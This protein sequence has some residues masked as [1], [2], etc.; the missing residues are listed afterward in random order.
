MKSYLA[1]LNFRRQSEKVHD[2]CNLLQQMLTPYISLAPAS[3]IC[4][5]ARTGHSVIQYPEPV[6]PVAQKTGLGLA[7]NF[8]RF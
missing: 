8:V 2:I 7:V 6:L 4:A 5:I 3:P 1:H